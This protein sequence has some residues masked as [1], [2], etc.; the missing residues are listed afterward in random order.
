MILNRL[1]KLEKKLNISKWLP[2]LFVKSADDIEVNRRLIGKETVVI[3]DDI[4]EGD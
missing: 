4:S 2:V 1:K 3:I